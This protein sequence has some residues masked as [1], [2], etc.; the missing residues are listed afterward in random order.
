[1]SY[2]P[3][4][5]VI[6]GGS[7]FIGT[8]LAQHLLDQGCT[9]TTVDMLPRSEKLDCEHRIW[10]VREAIPDSLTEPPET[11]FNLAAIHR[12]PGHPDRE[13]Y[14]TNVAG[15]IN[16]T[17]WASVTG[18]NS[19][20][21]TSSISVYGPGEE[22]KSESTP[23]TPVSPYGISKMMAEQIQTRWAQQTSE[24]VLKIIRPA[25]IFGPG[26]RG[27][28]TRLARA[29][30][31]NRFMY[32]GRNDTL[33]ACGYVR[34]LVRAVCF[35]LQQE[36]RIETFNYCYPNAYTI[37]DVCTAFHDIAGYSLP[38]SLPRSL[39]EIPL[40]ISHG[41]SLGAVRK[42][43]ERAEKLITSTNVVPSAL[44]RAGF[45][46]ETDLNSGLQEWYEA[47]GSVAFE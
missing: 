22:S 31:H 36:T 21:F 6:F 24:R 17:D 15:A 4:T 1:L 38:K 5:A 45:A 19:I 40:K 26:E 18:V 47:C 3:K 12:T 27:N 44:M 13:Y 10:D 42:Q 25:V 7:G 33:K 34:D 29:L 11:I 14:E 39:V 23:L 9:V 30:Q 35:S 20:S 8:H 2:V 32:P 43:V 16:I 28:F 46:W 37:Q 41:V